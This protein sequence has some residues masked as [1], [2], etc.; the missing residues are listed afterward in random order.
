MQYNTIFFAPRYIHCSSHLKAQILR[1]IVGVEIKRENRRYW[2][3]VCSSVVW[4][5]TNLK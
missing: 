4:S 3:N 2:V 5:V 1:G